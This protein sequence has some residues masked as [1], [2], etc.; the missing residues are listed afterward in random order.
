M[1]ESNSMNNQDTTF[2][3]DMDIGS[4]PDFVQSQTSQHRL[5]EGVSGKM[6]TI[7]PDIARV[8]CDTFA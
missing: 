8:T 5:P 4:I 7:T 3:Q 6:T 2:V 1:V